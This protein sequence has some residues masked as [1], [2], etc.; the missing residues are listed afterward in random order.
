[1]KIYK[2]LFILQEAHSERG[3]CVVFLFFFHI[4][5]PS[6]YGTLGELVSISD[7]MSVVFENSANSKTLQVHSNYS[8]PS[9]SCPTVSTQAIY[10]DFVRILRHNERATQFVTQKY[11]L[12]DHCHKL[13][14]V[15]NNHFQILAT[16]RN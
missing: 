6:G 2:L 5:F 11:V 8:L 13:E 9:N 1:M 16:L 10:G 4:L 15:G 3:I 14:K 12:E 7:L